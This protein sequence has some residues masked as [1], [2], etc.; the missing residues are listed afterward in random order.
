MLYRI[1][2]EDLNRSGIE[3]IISQYFDGFR[4][5]SDSGYWKGASED[6]LTIDIVAEEYEQPLIEK[7]ARKIKEVNHQESVLLQVFAN[8]FAFL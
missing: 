8:D 7:I 6:S 4:V 5:V 3:A 2:T 1:S